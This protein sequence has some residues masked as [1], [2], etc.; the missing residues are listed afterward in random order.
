MSSSWPCWSGCGTSFRLSFENLPII[1]AGYYFGSVAGAA[2]GIVA[3]VTGCI[4]VGYAI[5]PIITLGAALIGIIAGLCGTLSFTNKLLKAVITVVP[6]HIVGS[7]IVKTVG[8]IVYYSQPVLATFG[9]RL[10]IYTVTAAAESAILYILIKN[11]AFDRQ[12]RNPE[13]GER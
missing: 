7:V 4:L 11:R 3:D 5:N 1:L 9:W 6:A 2:V 12:M 8:L 10:L 13:N